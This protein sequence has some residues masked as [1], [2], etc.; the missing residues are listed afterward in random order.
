LLTART[1]RLSRA[2]YGLLILCVGLAL[3]GF[4][5]LAWANEEAQEEPAPEYSGMAPMLCLGC[6]GPRGMKP[7]AV[8]SP[9]HMVKQD[10]RA[11]WAE[12]NHACEAC[13]G[14][15]KAHAMSGGKK[16]P[17]VV[18]GADTAPED[19]SVACQ[20]CHGSDRD[21]F[22]WPGATHNI[23]GVACNDCH[24]IH[25]EI[26]PV[27]SVEQQT[28]TCYS[29]HAEQRALFLRQSR[30]PVQAAS[31]AFSHEG[32]MTC[33]DCHN[34]HG[35]DGPAQLKRST[36]NE[37][38]YD[39][40]AEKRGPFLWEHQPVRED[41]S[42]CHNPHGSNYPNLLTARTP[43]LCQQCHSAVNHSSTAMSGIDVAP[44]SFDR[45]IVGQDCMNCHGKVHGS[46]HPSGVALTR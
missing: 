27:L 42:N 13:H 9:A 24:S 40:H 43:W 20:S 6:H 28:E 35:S 21:R 36:V 10:P 23:E 15:S 26:D 14:P 38:C 8:I 11:P 29:C 45:R 31:N 22:H 17:A 32:L 18:F 34:P 25:Q 44:N 4:G 41:C 3:A 39:C 16:P 46:N 19:R 30:H 1:D 2:F 33:T 7:A 12:G 37:Q 5:S